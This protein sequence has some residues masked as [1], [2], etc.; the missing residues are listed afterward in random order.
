MLSITCS[1][2]KQQSTPTNKKNTL[3]WQNALKNS[4]VLQHLFT[5]KSNLHKKHSVLKE[6]IK[7]VGVMACQN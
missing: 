1:K 5:K 4:N 2:I 6:V 7:V 3:K